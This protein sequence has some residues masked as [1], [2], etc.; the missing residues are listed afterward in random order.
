[1]LSIASRPSAGGALEASSIYK[2]G[3]FWYLFVSWD[4]CCSGTSSTYNIRVGRSSSVTG[5][6]VDQNNVAL[7]NGGG[8]LV[9]ATRGN[10]I[11]PGGQDVYTDSDGPILVF[12]GLFFEFPGSSFAKFPIDYYT[13]SGQKLGINRL[14]FSS[15]WPV[16]CWSSCLLIRPLT[17]HRLL[18]KGRWKNRNTVFTHVNLR[19]CISPSQVEC[20]YGAGAFKPFAATLVR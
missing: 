19:K 1:M 11:G 5:P 6:F 2:N 9:L 7:T 17:S 16:S 13:S 12:R 4:R 20:R 3:N 10:V 18:S 8:T 14:S 15:G